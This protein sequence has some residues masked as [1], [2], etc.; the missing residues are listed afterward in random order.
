[1]TRSRYQICDSSYPHF[2]T[3]TIN[4]WPPVFTRPETMDIVLESWRFLQ[5]DSGFGLFGYVILENH[6]HLVARSQDLGKDIKRFKSYTAKAILAY[7]RDCKADRLLRLLEICKRKHKKE[8]IYQ[9]WEEGSHPQIIENE[10]VLIQKLD[11]I[12][13]NPVMRG[14]VDLAEHWRYS[15]ARDYDGQEGLI[16]ICRDW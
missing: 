15:S 10:S 9:I 16:D 6:V 12:H 13:Q 7:L 5:A 1:M 14:Y 2:L 3:A 4:N 11:Y 8:S